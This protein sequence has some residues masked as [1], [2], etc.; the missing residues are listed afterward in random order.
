[1]ARG[2]G[3]LRS[4]GLQVV[5]LEPEVVVEEV[6]E[7][8]VDVDAVVDDLVVAVVDCSAA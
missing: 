1:M 3:W 6:G 5:S 7:P 8:G 4:R 2:W